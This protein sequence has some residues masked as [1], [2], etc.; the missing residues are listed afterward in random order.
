M[1]Y[2]FPE[3][4]FGLSSFVSKLTII[5]MWIFRTHVR[6]KHVNWQKSCLSERTVLFELLQGAKQFR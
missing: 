6:K 3:I 5:S 4:S 2:G 1:L